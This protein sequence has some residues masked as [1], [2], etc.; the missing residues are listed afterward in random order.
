[1]KCIRVEKRFAE[2]LIFHLK[3]LNVIDDEYSFASDEYFIYIPIKQNSVK[4]LDDYDI[5]EHNCEKIMNCSKKIRNLR[6]FLISKGYQ[7]Y[8]K[9]FDIVGNVAIVEIPQEINEKDVAEGIL[10]IHKNIKS[11]Y[12]KNSARQGSFRLYD[13]RLIYGEDVEVVEHRENGLRFLVDIKNT[14]F[15]PR[16]GSER[17]YIAEYLSVYNF[18][19]VMVFFAGIGPFCIV[20]A[21]YNKNTKFYGIE[22]NERAYELFKKNI[23]LN[24]LAN[25]FAIHGDVKEKYKDFLDHNFDCVIM[26]LPKE[27]H[28][29]FNEAVSILK[30]EGLLIVYLFL[31]IENSKEKFNELLNSHFPKVKKLQMLD[32]KEIDSYSPYES[33]FRIIL[34]VSKN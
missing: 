18:E 10:F 3:D 9:S 28:L 11:I 20:C 29:F 25:V 13:L 34:K 27:S 33:K 8:V 23:E 24:R 5:V 1:M 14:F 32:F 30:N 19:K 17:K 4:Y 12:A 7:N 15:S 22:L 2:E 21:K 6:D 26:P 31:P 16:T